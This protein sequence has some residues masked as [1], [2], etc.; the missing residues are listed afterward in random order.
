MEKFELG[1]TYEWSTECGSWLLAIVIL[2]LANGETHRYAMPLA[3][4][5]ED[6]GESRLTALLPATLAKGTA[7][8]AYGR[9]V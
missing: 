3:L 9:A 8:R 4:A 7:A 1:E 6:E 2:T 5:W